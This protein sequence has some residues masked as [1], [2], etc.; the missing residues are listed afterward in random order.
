MVG[1]IFER[2]YYT[3]HG[4]LAQ[5]LE[6]RLAEQL[7]VRNA[8][9]VTNEFIGLALVGQALEIRGN[10]L[11]PALSFIGTSQSLD[12]TNG[13]P[14]FCDVAPETGVM[15]AEVAGEIVERQRV[16]AILA[17]NPWGDACDVEGLQRLAEEHGIPLYIESSH[18][19]GCS[20]ADRSIGAVGAAEVI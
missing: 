7:Q 18:G 6:R 20:I 16:S 10:V 5:E 4:Q 17:V 19:F 11:V 14:H 12:W 9:C 3:N 8:M 15:T 2:Q 1:R 13:I